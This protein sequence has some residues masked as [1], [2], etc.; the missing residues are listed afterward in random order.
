MGRKRIRMDLKGVCEIMGSTEK[1]HQ[2]LV[3]TSSFNNRAR[4]ADESTRQQIK[5]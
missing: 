1:I 4:G 3:F 2:L 5:N